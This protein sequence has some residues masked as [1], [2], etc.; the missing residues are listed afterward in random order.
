M[1][2]KL[3]ALS[4]SSQSGQAQA[5]LAH[6]PRLLEGWVEV[7]RG[8]LTLSQDINQG[9]PV[10]AL[11]R[12]ELPCPSQ[13]R[14]EAAVQ[15]ANAVGGQESGQEGGRAWGAFWETLAISEAPAK[16]TAVVVVGEVMRG[17]KEV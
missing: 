14:W 15:V 2:Q 3:Q 5:L 11:T 6:L 17:R 8:D 4:P 16:D 7:S 1:H 9:S 13:A 10:L 12:E